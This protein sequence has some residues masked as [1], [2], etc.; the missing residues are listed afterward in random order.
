MGIPH[1]LGRSV[2]ITDWGGHRTWS[3]RSNVPFPT[4]TVFRGQ[5]A[6][7]P[8]VS[9]EQRPISIGEMVVILGGNPTLGLSNFLDHPDD[10]PTT[11]SYY[12]RDV[13]LQSLW[14]AMRN[15]DSG[16]FRHFLSR[17]GGKTGV[18][19]SAATFFPNLLGQI[20]GE[21]GL[22]ATLSGIAPTARSRYISG[23]NQWV[24]FVE[25]QH[26]SHWIPRNSENWGDL[27]IDFVLFEAKVIGDAFPAIRGKLSVT[28]FWNV[29]SD[30]ADFIAGGGWLKPAM[31]AWNANTRFSENDPLRTT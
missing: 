12:P 21:G 29:V 30:R 22:V 9:P 6:H 27:L 17:A 5:E 24:N 3:M 2:V 28:S 23:R 14:A 7:W 26:R 13:A 11:G 15:Y 25:S 16:N 8:L 18:E 1:S 19:I 4:I 10:E 31:K 20:Y